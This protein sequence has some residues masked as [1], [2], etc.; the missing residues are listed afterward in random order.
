MQT[1]IAVFYIDSGLQPWVHGIKLFLNSL[2]GQVGRVLRELT[3]VLQFLSEFFLRMSL[4]PRFWGGSQESYHF[5]FTLSQ[6]RERET[7]VL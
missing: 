4:S 2:R 3:T 1:D 5:L 6:D 7:H